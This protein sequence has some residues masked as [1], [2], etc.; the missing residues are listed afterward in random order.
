MWEKVAGQTDDTIIVLRRPGRGWRDGAVEVAG[1]GLIVRDLTIGGLRDSG[2]LFRSARDRGS[3]AVDVLINRQ[4]AR[5]RGEM[6][7]KTFA[8]GIEIERPARP[9]SIY[10]LEL[11]AQRETELDLTVECSKGTYIRSLVED[12]GQAMG[13]GAH[14]SMFGL[15]RGTPA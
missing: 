8:K 1:R 9:V 3:D 7:L 10:K 4:G 6:P 12:I 15:L 2:R 11:G 13:C 14:V 5:S